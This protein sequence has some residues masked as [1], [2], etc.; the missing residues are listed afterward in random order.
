[1][2]DYS[3]VDYRRMIAWPQRIEREWPLLR[4]KLERGPSRRILE[5][6]SGTGEHARFLVEQ[7]YQVVGVDASE[8]MI[9]KSTET[10]LP[11][12]LELIQGDMRQLEEL[13]EGEFGAAI[14]L[15]NSLP[16]LRGSEDLVTLASALRARLLPGSPFLLQILNYERIFRSGQRHLPLNFRKDEEGNEVVFLRIM[17]PREDGSL[18]FFPTT[19]R[20]D[21]DA[22]E[23]V[24]VAGTKRVELRGWR[25]WEIVEAFTHAGFGHFELYGGFDKSPY[26]P[27]QS[28]DLVLICWRG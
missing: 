1:M 25:S 8:T 2:D 15:G 22:G 21:P 27:Q 10:E 20:L 23:P 4:E 26:D 24:S 19:L 14:C 28:Q 11:E 7:G 13:V 18:L 5:L 6:G 12:G 16:H 9:L 3:R 17:S